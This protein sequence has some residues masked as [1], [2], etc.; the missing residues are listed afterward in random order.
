MR[1]VEREAKRIGLERTLTA[2]DEMSDLE[3]EENE[4]R[5]REM[6]RENIERTKRATGHSEAMIRAHNITSD[7]AQPTRGFGP[8]WGIDD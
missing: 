1:R 8:L 4:R 7:A 5:A 2:I 3:F 6:R